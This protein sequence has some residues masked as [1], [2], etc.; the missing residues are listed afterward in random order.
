MSRKSVIGGNDTVTR[1][2]ILSLMLAILLA[3]AKYDEQKLPYTAPWGPYRVLVES[4]QR[5]E[6]SLHRVRILDGEGHPLREVRDAR[7]LAAAFLE[8]TGGRDPEL[9]VSTYTDGAHC[10]T[11]D[12]YFTREGGVRNL[13]IFDGFNGGVIAAKDLNGDGRPELIASSDTLAYF[14][15]I[16]YAQS[17][18]IRMVIG[19]DGRRYTDQTRRYPDG[20]RREVRRYQDAFLATFKQRDQWAE[21]SR[22]GAAAGSYANALA[23]GEGAAARRWLMRHAPVIT[24][25]WLRENE[26]KLRAAVAEGRSKIRVSQQTVLEAPTIRSTAQ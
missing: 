14:G 13:L 2:S 3:P 5:G 26:P 11:T 19:W 21:E 12:Y 1:A 9:H 15:G 20:S 18:W 8:L 25:R 23:I 24:W 16:S 4:F 7:V 10:C 22:R 17:P 6:E